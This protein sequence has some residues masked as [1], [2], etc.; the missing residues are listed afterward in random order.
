VTAD[1]ARD[2]E[3]EFTPLF[4]EDAPKLLDALEV[5]PRLLRCAVPSRET[6]HGSA[7]RLR[8]ARCRCG[9]RY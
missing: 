7:N 9:C 2:G 6:P 4:G 1:G 3:Q 8:I 5:K